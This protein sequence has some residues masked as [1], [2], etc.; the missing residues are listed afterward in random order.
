M[1]RK[2]VHMIK[3]RVVTLQKSLYDSLE[4]KC[5][6]LKTSS[7]CT[8][9][10][11][12]SNDSKSA[13]YQLQPN[14][15]KSISKNFQRT[16]VSWKFYQCSRWFE[17]AIDLGAASKRSAFFTFFTVNQ[18]VDSAGHLYASFNLGFPENLK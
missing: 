11:R 3:P 2:Q 6:P 18:S 12:D 1:V 5:C 10:K 9:Q 8:N 13:S 15:G 16:I 4:K 14:F 7:N 17:L